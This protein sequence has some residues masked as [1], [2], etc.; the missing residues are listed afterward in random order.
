M[1]RIYPNPTSSPTRQMTSFL[2]LIVSLIIRYFRILLLKEEDIIM[3]HR[4]IFPIMY[5]VSKYFLFHQGHAACNKEKKNER[6]FAGV[7]GGEDRC[8][9]SAE[10]ELRKIVCIYKRIKENSMYLYEVAAV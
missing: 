3:K 1:F 5:T 8:A 7:W 2:L 4:T 10:K 9:A 6:E